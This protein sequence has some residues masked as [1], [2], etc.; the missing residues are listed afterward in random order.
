MLQL[1]L[2][3][4]PS[5]DLPAVTVYTTSPGTAS[6]QGMPRLR[7][8]RLSIAHCTPI[9]VATNRHPTTCQSQ[10]GPCI[11]QGRM[12]VEADDVDDGARVGRQGAS[13]SVAMTMLLLLL[14]HAVSPSLIR[15]GWSRA[16][17]RFLPR[18]S[19]QCWRSLLPGRSCTALLM[20]QRVKPCNGS[21]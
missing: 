2:L 10:S 8:Q 14:M 17:A 19:T 5:S 21:T 1:P 13:S 9:V 18:G 7:R 6:A 3:L 4:A 15:W 16:R 20:R 12:S 11:V